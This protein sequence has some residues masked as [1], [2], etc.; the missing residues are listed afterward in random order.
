MDQDQLTTSIPAPP[1]GF[2]LDVPEPPAGFTV[3]AKAEIPPPPPG[4]VL[5]APAG[6][7]EFGATEPVELKTQETPPLLPQEPEI[8]APSPI[9]G[10]PR[11]YPQVATRFSRPGQP[12][13][14]AE[15]AKLLG[16]DITRIP[17]T[18]AETGKTALGGVFSGG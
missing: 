11:P 16:E 18:V 12:Q 8:V 2:V 5:D 7:P 1:P 9:Q 3:N 6:T 4:F 13:V 17:R 10:P 15:Q 14:L